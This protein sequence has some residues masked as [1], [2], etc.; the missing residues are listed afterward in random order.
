MQV[1]GMKRLPYNT[2]KFA[3]FSIKTSYGY[4]AVL[5]INTLLGVWQNQQFSVVSNPSIPYAKAVQI[6]NLTDAVVFWGTIITLGYIVLSVII[7]GVWIY[8]ASKN[9]A[10]IAPDERRIRPG[11]A[12]GWFVVPIANLW[13]P[14]QAM[15]ETW[16]SSVAKQDILDTNLPSLIG[17]WWAAWIV[18]NILS[19]GFNRIQA[20]TE[21]MDVYIAINYA[22]IGTAILGTITAVLFIRI[23]REVSDAHAAWDAKIAAEL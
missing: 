2:A 6:A 15:K 1:A 11:W 13:K 8:R 4:I 22:Y 21:D 7:N 17:Y 18:L 20:K 12:V 3:R 5:W 19:R 9:A 14:Y 10:A 23:M 16:N